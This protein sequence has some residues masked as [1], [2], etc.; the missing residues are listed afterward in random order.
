LVASGFSV[1]DPAFSLCAGAAKLAW[2]SAE[3]GGESP[4]VAYARYV[5]PLVGVTRGKVAETHLDAVA[6]MTALVPLT[7]LLG[8]TVS[9]YRADPASVTEEERRLLDVASEVGR[10]TIDMAQAYRAT[11]ELVT[12]MQILDVD[13]YDRVLGRLY[14]AR[15]DPPLDAGTIL[16]TVPEMN[17]TIN[18]PAGP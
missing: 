8:S 4:E 3:P 12:E 16:A 9:A 14:G 5:N 2:A 17:D 7:D 18:S 11:A 15:S 6:A 10:G 1:F 13:L